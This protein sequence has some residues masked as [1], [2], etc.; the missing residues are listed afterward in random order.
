MPEKSTAVHA[1][2]LAGRGAGVSVRSLYQVFPN[3]E[4]VI[5][6]LIERHADEAVGSCSAHRHLGASPQKHR[7]RRSCWLRPTAGPQRLAIPADSALD[8][9]P[10]R[11]GVRSL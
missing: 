10:R 4:A 8:G 1:P 2:P 3:K 7:R 11:L 6:V 9:D 5:A